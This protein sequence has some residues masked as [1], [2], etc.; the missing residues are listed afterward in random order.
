MAMT[1]KKE[2]CTETNIAEQGRADKEEKK[3]LNRKALRKNERQW[4]IAGD[5]RD[6]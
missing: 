2:K 3:K 6:K 5:N 1:E 4:S